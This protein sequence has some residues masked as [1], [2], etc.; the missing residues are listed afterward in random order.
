[1]A[2]TALKAGT[3]LASV[4]VVL[5]ALLYRPTPDGALGDRLEAVLAGLIRVERQHQVTPSTRVA[6]G[7]GACKDLFAEAG[8]VFGQ[9]QHTAKPAHFDD[10]NTREQVVDTFAYFFR[11]GAAAE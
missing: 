6:V 1:M 9:E 7:Y 10:I 5:L 8:Q 4:C 11:H 3:Y 2:V